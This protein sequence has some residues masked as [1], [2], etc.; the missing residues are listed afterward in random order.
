MSCDLHVHSVHSMETGHFLLR[1]LGA[2][3]SFTPPAVIYDLAKKRGMDLVT[4]TDINTIDGVMEIAHN[5]DVFI[6]EE[7]KTSLP[8]A[9]SLVH[10][11][12]FDIS[13]GQHD[14]IVRARDRFDDL[15]DY[16]DGQG[17]V[18]CLAHP[19]Y[20]PG[21]DLSVEEF[22]HV[23]ERVGLVEAR[24]GT[25]SRQENEA[26]IPVVR[27]IK[28]DESFNGF[29]AGSDDHCGR[30]VAH[31][32]TTV[33]GASTKAGFLEGL[34]D[35]KGI[36]SG[37]DGSAFRAAYSVYSIAYSFLRDRLMSKNTPTV[38][39][40][41]ADRFFHPGS[42]FE[43]PT[44]WH[45]A[46]FV[47]HQLI[48]KA[49]RS[50]ETDFESVLVDEL[51]EIGRDLNIAQPDQMVDREEQIDER[52]F[53]I[54]NRLTNRLLRH[55][56]SVLVKRVASG[57]ILDALEA[58]TAIIPVILL[59]APYPISYIYSRRGRD[60]VRTLSSTLVGTDLSG[61]DQ[62][63]RAWFTDTIDDLNGVSRTIQKYSKLAAS[64][65][66]RLAIIACQGRALS[67]PGWV[68][69]F[70]PLR[71]FSVPDYHSKLLSVPPFLE[72]LRFIE[73]NNFGVLYISTPGPVGFAALGI[74]KLLGLKSVGIYH[75]DLPRHVNQIVQ[76]AR[77]GELAASG[78]AFFYGAVDVV[79]V[80]SHYYMDDLVAMGV[81]R[82]KM[83]I[84]PRG[85]DC[86][87][88][89]PEWRDRDFYSAYGGSPESLKL[90]YVGRVSR[91]K[92]LDV[93][94]DAFL[95]V[96]EA[97]ADGGEE[98]REVELFFVGDGPYI[99]DLTRKLSGHGAFFC[100]TLLGESL[101]KAYASADVFV[102][103]STTDTYGNSV[104]EAQ[105]AGLP[106]V[107]TDMGGP[108]EIIEPDA[109]GLVCRGRDAGDMA[110]CIS[111]LLDDSDL[112]TGMGK[113]ARRIA[114]EKTWEK[115]FLTLW[116]DTL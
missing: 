98:S 68:V 116:D 55:F 3:E 112:R 6:S 63:L 21:S 111:R 39:T 70:Q 71:E 96:R 52:T 82:G 18:H 103:P 48:K 86:D 50:G 46:D 27:A 62:E 10:I 15:I 80:P 29:T 76:D 101:S 57:R 32:Y 78:V 51:V 49:T 23:V 79:M 100:G 19:F 4:I 38:A 11:L 66:K 77:M 95:G 113:A 53:E 35:Q 110:D 109:T 87:Q 7:I 90:A 45:K 17:I 85:T 9:S 92:D 30:F 114:L 25:R 107:V 81:D 115:A 74:A 105:A 1:R 24:N 58:L 26:A 34:N 59:N 14:E 88:F 67:F 12:A 2:P 102:F 83:K 108:K 16:L 37:E 33:H 106:A 8:G 91:E 40:M 5:P 36:L 65:E 89:S 75:T 69:N 94:A 31:T 73:E 99:G 93:L 13:P 72:T 64:L 44:L 41:A 97:R 104:L 56:S 43:E 84:F 47:F 28:G 22:R 20:F 42:A 61:R 54:L 60:A